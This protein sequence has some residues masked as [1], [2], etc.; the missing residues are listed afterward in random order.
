[1]ARLGDTELDDFGIFWYITHIMHII[2]ATTNGTFLSI[3]NGTN[4]SFV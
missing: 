2:S 4:F 3:D 1:M